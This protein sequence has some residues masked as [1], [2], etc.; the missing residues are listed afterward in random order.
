[1][2]KLIY[3]VLLAATCSLMLNACKSKDKDHSDDEIEDLT[4]V[5]TPDALA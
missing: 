3:L 4:L 5:V 1:M 2:R